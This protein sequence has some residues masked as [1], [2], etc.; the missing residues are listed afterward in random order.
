M[1]WRDKQCAKALKEKRERE[2]HEL[3]QHQAVWAAH[4]ARVEKEE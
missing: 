1:M 3:K 2:A 4:L